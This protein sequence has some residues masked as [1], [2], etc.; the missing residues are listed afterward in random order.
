[1]FDSLPS[2][3]FLCKVKN[4]VVDKEIKNE[5]LKIDSFCNL[6]F[7]KCVCITFTTT[8]EFEK[9]QNLP[10]QILFVFHLPFPYALDAHRLQ[11][12]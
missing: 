1:V 4:F 6:E 12:Y 10:E 5:K 3:V 11:F 8:I 2:I 7:G 9:V